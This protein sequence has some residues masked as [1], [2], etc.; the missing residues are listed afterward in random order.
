MS[1]VLPRCYREVEIGI[2]SEAARLD[3][4]TKLLSKFPHRLSTSH[5]LHCSSI[6]HGYVGADLL[7]VCKEAAQAALKRC[8]L[9][10]TASS[11]MIPRPPKPCARFLHVFVHV[12]L[13]CTNGCI[14]VLSYR[15]VVQVSGSA[16][17]C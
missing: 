2:P 6:T 4:L 12:R 3:I 10:Q 1:L 5:I 15:W 8:V 11:G 17:T 14:I 9:D 16:H 13:F 7:A